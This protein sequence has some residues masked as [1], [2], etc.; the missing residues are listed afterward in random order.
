MEDAAPRGRFSIWLLGLILG[1][2]V[3]MLW[4]GRGRLAL[5]Y[6]LAGLL[7]GVALLFAVANGLITPPAWTDFGMAAVLFSIPFNIIGLVHGLMIRAT[8]LSRPWFSRWYAAIILP[9]AVSWLLPFLVR[10]CLYQSYN[11]PS[12]SMVPSIVIGDYFLVSKAAYGYS[13]LSFSGGFMNFPGRIWASEPRRGDIV[14]FKLP[15]DNETD[16]I[17]RLIGIPGDRIQMKDGI[18]HLNGQALPLTR[19]QDIP[20]IEGERC[21]FFRE[22]LPNGR[23]YVINNATQNGSVDN[24]EEYVVPEGHYFMLGDNRD[25]SLDSR[26]GEPNGIGYIPYENLVGPVTLIF[27]NSMG[28]RIDDR[29]AGYPSRLTTP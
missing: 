6:F 21:N 17:K 9:L 16:Y 24:T 2:V 25:N 15:R 4:L 11:A 12:L 20:C 23:S 13:R 28:M 10:E 22:T 26:F 5:V 27:W 19:V 8:A 14:V 29:L 18:V 1:P 3:L 7:L